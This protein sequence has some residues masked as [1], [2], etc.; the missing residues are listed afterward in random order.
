MFFIFII[1]IQHA[2]TLN[3]VRAAERGHRTEGVVT[4]TIDSHFDRI[5]FPKMSF[6]GNPQLSSEHHLLH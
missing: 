2:N 4:E 1:I 6:S 3:T 5:M